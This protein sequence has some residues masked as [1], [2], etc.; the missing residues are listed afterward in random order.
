M[1]WHARLEQA[2][3]HQEIGS[4]LSSAQWAAQARAWSRIT[5]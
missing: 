3:S 1:F 4:G 5:A 2:L